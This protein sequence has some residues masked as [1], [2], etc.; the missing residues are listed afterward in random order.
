[1]PG[2]EPNILV[3]AADSRERGRLAATI[4]DAGFAVFA[5]AEPSG[6]LAAFDEQDFAAAVLAPQTDDGTALLRE[7]RRRQPGLPTV[8]VLPPAALRLVEADGATIVKRPLD[9]RQV[10]GCVFEIVLRDAPP[11]CAP[12]SRAAELG[13]A[14][15]QLACLDNR[16][17]TAAASGQ[18]CLE[19]RLTRQIGHVRDAC[20]SLTDAA[21]GGEA[22]S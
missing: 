12:H 13:I 11:G 17:T 22:A 1:M 8:L 9:P 5:V 21:A 14:A 6:A 2:N 19:R 10:L 15:A 7:A 16:R 20:R 3:V 18:G 4:S